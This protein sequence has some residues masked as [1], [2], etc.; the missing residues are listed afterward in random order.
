MYVFVEKTFYKTISVL[1]D[2]PLFMVNTQCFSIVNNSYLKFIYFLN[3][4]LRSRANFR[5]IFGRLILNKNITIAITV[6]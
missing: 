5:K 2:K 4:S 6:L 1:R 3:L